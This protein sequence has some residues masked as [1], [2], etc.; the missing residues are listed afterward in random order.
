MCCKHK[1]KKNTNFGTIFRNINATTVFF[2]EFPKEKYF[3]Q[4]RFNKQRLNRLKID[5]Q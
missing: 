2:I 5:L 4:I 1:I 3:V